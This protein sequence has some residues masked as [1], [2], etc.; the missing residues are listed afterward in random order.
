MD[1]IV[2]VSHLI[3]SLTD[4]TETKQAKIS[5]STL[6]MAAINEFFNIIH[7][8]T[9]NKKTARFIMPQNSITVLI[10]HRPKPLEDIYTWLLG[11]QLS[12]TGITSILMQLI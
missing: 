5:T 2:S 4:D 6:R 8:S 9:L 11:N 10:D 1:G 3:S 7:C 12:S